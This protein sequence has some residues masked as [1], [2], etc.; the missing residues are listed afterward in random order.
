[1]GH[2]SLPRQLHQIHTNKTS[3]SVAQK[4]MGTRNNKFVDDAN[5]FSATKFGICLAI[6]FVIVIYLT[7]DWTQIL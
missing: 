4:L 1:M 7:I 3:A 6:L 5:E 2:V